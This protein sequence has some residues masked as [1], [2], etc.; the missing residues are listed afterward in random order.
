[1]N[2]K[3]GD[4]AVIVGGRDFQDDCKHHIGKVVRVER[5]VSGIVF[6]ELMIGWKAEPILTETTT[7]GEV[8]WVDHHLRPIR[9]NDGEDEMLRIAGKPQEVTA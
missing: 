7:G 4:M 5:M 9:D 6:G 2:C 8:Y 1:M 3:P